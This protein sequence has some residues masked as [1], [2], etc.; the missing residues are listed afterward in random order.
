MGTAKADRAETI[1][2]LRARHEAF[3]IA[4][5][6]LRGDGVDVEHFTCH[7]CAAQLDGKH[8]NTEVAIDCS[9]CG[10]L[11]ELPCHLRYRVAPCEDEVGALS[12]ESSAYHAPPWWQEYVPMATS[13]EPAIPV[14]PAPMWLKVFCLT[15]L[16]AVLVAVT[17]LFLQGR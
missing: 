11:N 14:E 7:A 16:A 17:F 15:C 9:I 4:E 12:Y 8:T 5:A 6:I 13:V 3:R 1:V 2:A 10:A